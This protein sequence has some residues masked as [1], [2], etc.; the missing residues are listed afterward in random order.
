MAGSIV[1]TTREVVNNILK[2][3]VT[4]T[5]DASGDVNG[6][7]F[8]MAVGTLLAVEFVPGAGGVAPTTQYDVDLIDDL[9]LSLF[10]DGAGT[11]VGFNLS[12]TLA[13]HRV[14]LIGQAGI[15]VYRRWHHGGS[16]QPTI[17]GAG[18]AKQGTIHIYL[19]FG[20]L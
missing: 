17:S 20:V 15:T 8:A 16:V 11:S 13:S 2:Y 3:S 7:S 6:T 9:S 4:W 18:N 1:V 14:P 10:D 12:S 19:S 5:S